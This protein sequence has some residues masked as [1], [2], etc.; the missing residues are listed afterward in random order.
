MSLNDLFKNIST[1]STDSKHSRSGWINLKCPYCR[2]NH[3]HLGFNIKHQYFTCF[4]CGKKP[5]IKTLIKLT[6]LNTHDIINLLKQSKGSYTG[7]IKATN[8]KP[9]KTPTKLIRLSQSKIHKQYLKH[10]GFNW[11]TLTKEYDLKCTR[12]SKLDDIDFSWRIYI[13]IYY[14]NELV[15][16][17]TRAIGKSSVPYLACPKELEI[18]N[19]KD[20]LYPE[21]LSHT[22]FLVEGLFDCWKV[23]KAGFPAVCGFGAGLEPKQIRK[24]STKRVIIFYDGDETGIK[25]A[26]EI[27]NRIEFINGKGVEI[28][29]CPKGKDP[30]NLNSKQ[31]TK[32]L[33]EYL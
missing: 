17:Q 16:Y 14:L 6:G 13:P 10:R 9:F 23:R 1:A 25:K 28:A 5:L 12:L 31:I 3:H 29:T 11:K 33:K 2:T 21:E 26:E 8:K 18:I 32:I 19:I 30:G 15:T 4:S 24:L 22:V 27:K 7:T 20:L